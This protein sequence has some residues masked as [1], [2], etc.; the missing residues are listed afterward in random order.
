MERDK[1]TETETEPTERAH[2]ER[3]YRKIEVRERASQVHVFCKRVLP[4][5]ITDGS[6]HL[7]WAVDS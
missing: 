2:S 5:P 7:L 6:G 4:Q 3:A 1:E